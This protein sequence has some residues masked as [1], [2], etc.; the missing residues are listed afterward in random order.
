MSFRSAPNPNLPFSL[1]QEQTTICSL[2]ASLCFPA[3]FFCSHC[4]CVCVCV[5]FASASLYP[6]FKDRQG[7]ASDG[8]D[9]PIDPFSTSN[10]SVAFEKNELAKTPKAKDQK[11]KKEKKSA[12]SS[13]PGVF[14]APNRG[15]GAIGELSI[16]AAA[17]S[18]CIFFF[19]LFERSDIW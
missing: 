7:R 5:L 2:I 14:E 3:F 9:C 16:E 12:H 10:S 18:Q 15:R 1:C 6:L 13:F 8:S 19:F 4:V 17:M 11:K